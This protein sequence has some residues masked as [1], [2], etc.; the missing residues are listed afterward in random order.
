MF[1]AFG[2]LTTPHT[3]KNLSIK[4]DDDRIVDINKAS[5]DIF[6]EI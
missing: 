2:L 4:A 5:F 3:L 1:E 6:T